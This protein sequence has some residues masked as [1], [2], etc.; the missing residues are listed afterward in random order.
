MLNKLLEIGMS[1][2]WITPVLAQVQN[3]ANGPHR[4]FLVSGGSGWSG[5]RIE[6][7]LRDNGVRCWGMMIVS[8]KLMLTVRQ[9]QAGWTQY[10]LQREGIPLLNPIASAH[11]A[12]TNG[13]AA[14]S[15]AREPRTAQRQQIVDRVSG[16]LDSVADRLGL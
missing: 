6:R 2:D 5:H 3:V 13:G 4:T 10:L 11:V 1:F 15:R 16:L 9:E 7:L 12:T 8:Q 14:L